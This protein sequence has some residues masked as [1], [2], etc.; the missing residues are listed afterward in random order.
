MVG[1]FALATLLPP[2]LPLAQLVGMYDS[3]LLFAVHDF[4]TANLPGW[5]WLDLMLPILTRPCWLLPASLGIVLAGA[6]M[7]AASRTGVP[8]SHRKRS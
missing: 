5:V 8:R 4:M 6:A 2:M 1:A 7:T 3:K